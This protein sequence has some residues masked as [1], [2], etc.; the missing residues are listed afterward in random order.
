[1]TL[2]EALQEKSQILPANPGWQQCLQDVFTVYQPSVADFA[3]AIYTTWTAAGVAPASRVSFVQLTAGLNGINDAAGNPVYGMAAIGPVVNGFY[4]EVMIYVDTVT[5][6][7][8]IGTSTQQPGNTSA[9]ISMSD[10][11]PN[12]DH[13]QGG[14]CELDDEG[15]VGNMTIHWR[16]ASSSAATDSVMLTAFRVSNGNWTDLASMP[17][18]LADGSWVAY[19]NP[20][21]TPDTTVTYAFDFMINNCTVTFW[22]DPYIGDH[23]KGKQA[24]ALA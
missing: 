18:K 2:L 8:E 11:H 12:D 22:F 4:M 19:A 3:Q 20:V 5:L 17:L 9:L 21:P 23:D 1:M 13:D 7:N 14:T 16:A 6:R 10:N 15:L 24:P